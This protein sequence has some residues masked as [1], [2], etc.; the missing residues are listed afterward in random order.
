M[1]KKSG[2]IVKLNQEGRIYLISSSTI[3]SLAFYGWAVPASLDVQDGTTMLTL[4][5][6]TAASGILI[7]YFMTNNARVSIGD[8]AMTSAGQFVGIMH[9]A[10]IPYLFQKDPDHTAILGSMFLFSVAEGIAGYQISRNYNYYDGKGLLIRNA[11]FMGAGWG[12]MLSGGLDLFEQ[13]KIREFLALSLISSAAFDVAAANMADNQF[14]TSGDVDMIT[15]PFVL[16]AMAGASIGMIAD[17]NNFRTMF[18]GASL[19]S[20]AGGAYGYYLTEG[21]DFSS[22]DG[23]ITELATLGGGLIGAGVGYLISSSNIDKPG[24]QIF[25]DVITCSSIAGIGTYAICYNAFK[26]DSKAEKGFKTSLDYFV[27]PMA[28]MNKNPNLS[29]PLAGVNI[30]F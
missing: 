21:Y 10:A 25:R 28:F 27:N 26:K 13:S 14:L 23:A 7:P 16:G 22:F 11:N 29:V 20:L 9:G 8:A 17:L 30:K 12:T 1:N 15:T 2:E 19:L 3:I 4:Y 6:A 5:M 24:E 18:Y